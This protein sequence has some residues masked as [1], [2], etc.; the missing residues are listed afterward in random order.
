[1]DG[2][3][4]GYWL[5]SSLGLYRADGVL[6]N[7]FL[8]N[9]IFILLCCL[10][11]TEHDL[12]FTGDLFLNWLTELG[13]YCADDV[14]LNLFLLCWLFLTEHGLS[15]TKGVFRVLYF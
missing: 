10:F 1:M 3:C 7:L 13:V 6:L 15:F 12:F 4:P 8:L 5:L 9:T 14:V 11:L 2:Y